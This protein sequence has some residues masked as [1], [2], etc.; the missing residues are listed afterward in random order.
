[1]ADYTDAEIEQA[2]KAADDGTK[3]V[4]A[5]LA[6]IIRAVRNKEMYNRYDSVVIGPTAKEFDD[7]WFNSF[8]EFA[9]ASKV[10]FFK[11]RNSAVGDAWA[12]QTTERLDYAQD[13]YTFSIEM[14]A[15]VGLGDFDEQALDSVFWPQYWTTTAAQQMS[16][17]VKL[18]DTDPIY[19]G[20]L[21]HVPAGVGA[22]GLTATDTAGPIVQPGTNGIGYMKNVWVWPEP[23]MIPAKGQ[24]TVEVQLANPLKEFLLLYAASPGNKLVPQE[25]PG[26]QGETNPLPNW[27]SMRATFRGPRYLQL[28]GARSA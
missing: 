23:V 17:V 3:R 7:G 26:P 20:P 28:R 19:T 6:A 12:N 16:C 8:A 9:R 24:L 1:M 22:A 4:P 25:P 18:A 11:G 27:F 10:V 2:A 5:D 13:L 21:T 14:N 15:P